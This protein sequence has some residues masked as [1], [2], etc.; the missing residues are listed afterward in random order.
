MLKIW[1]RHTS[2][3]VQKVMW[4]VGE[5]GIEYERTDVGGMHGGLDTQAFAA[6]NPNRRIPVIEDEGTLVWESNA[7]VRYLCERYAHCTLHPTN[8]ATR[9]RADQ[10]M[11][12]MSWTLEP[13][14]I[15]VFHRLYRTPPEKRDR[16]A[17]TAAVERINLLYTLLDAHLRDQPFVAG[18]QFTMGDIPIGMTLYRYYELMGISRP[19]LIH[20]EQYYQHLCDRPAYRAHIMMDQQTLHWTQHPV[21]IS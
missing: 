15:Y 19:T 10:W 8:P 4:A 5:L 13:D 21:E 12:W 9:A 1:G 6:L 7:I 2:S 18:E 14:W 17:I 20:L 11:D 16:A 3:N